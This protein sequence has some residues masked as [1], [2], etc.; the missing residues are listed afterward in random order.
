MER[1]VNI[2]VDFGYVLI[3]GILGMVSLFLKIPKE[4]GMEC[5]KKARKALG[6]GLVILATYCIVRLIFPQHHGDFEDFWMMVTIT[7][8]FS[9][10]TYSSLL[11]LMETP[12]YK[13]RH[14]FIDG[15]APTAVLIICGMIGIFFPSIQKPALIIFGS[16][17]SLKCIWMFYTCL[18]EYRQCQ[19]D[20]DNYYDEGPD[21]KWIRNIIYI[22]LILSVLTVLAFYVTET[23]VI[24]YPL[25]PIVYIYIVLKVVNFMPKKIDEV[26]QKNLL[27]DNKADE[28]KKLKVKD[29][30]EKIGPKIE[31]WVEEKK[32]CNANITI[33]DVATE[34]GT[35]HNYLSAYINKH[36]NVT[37]QVWL[38]TLRIEESKNLL[39]SGEKLSIEEIGAKVGIPQ[40]YN[41]SR[42][43]R[44]V[45]DMTPFQYKKGLMKNVR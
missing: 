45:T 2:L 17:F 31:K 14:F 8:I 11:F 37:F 38:N 6:I 33:K 43:F 39:A 18:K 35:N 41:F 34:I 22:S 23:H 7:L 15:I 12:R 1:L 42:W 16:T 10:L 26:R 3:F 5:Y 32:F 9:W 44:V 13:T 19:R 21:I 25:V 29:L 27:I 24:Y 30:N 40:N 28:G 36:L 20:L 4:Q